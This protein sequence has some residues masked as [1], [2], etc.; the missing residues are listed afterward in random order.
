MKRALGCLLLALSLMGCGHSG[1][2]EDAGKKTS[3]DGK[4][5]KPAE[6]SG[7]TAPTQVSI[8]DAAQAKAGITVEPVRVTEL[9]EYLTASGQ[10]VMNE[11]RTAHIGSY[12][13]GR[14]TELHANIGD[15]VHKGSILA[16][17]H[18]HDVHETIAAYQTALES[19]TRQKT[20][21]AY[22]QRMRDRMVRLLDLKSASR[23]E[24]EKA[25]S[26]L[27]SAQTDLTNSQIS[28]DK[29][30]AHLT[31]ILNLPPSS[32]SSIDENT[33]QIPVISTLSGVVIDRKISVGSVVEPGEEVF[34]VSDLSSVWM[35]AS[36]NET[37]IAKVRVGNSAEIV[38][39]AFPGEE[40]PGRI[41]RLGTELDPRTRTLQVRILVPNRGFKLR[42][43][44][45]VNAK[46]AQ[47][48]SR[49]AMFIP[50]LAIQEIN[51]GSVVFTRRPNN[52]FE[53][54][55][56]QIA[57][58]LNGTAEIAAGL[59]AGDELVVKGSFVVKSEILKSQIGE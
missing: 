14:V 26:D 1:G 47:G 4:G 45:Y 9:P 50:E 27:R 31:D 40:F 42:S 34:T 41:T 19:V 56:V 54:T 8:D 44:M 37:D 17:M 39:Q 25:E 32:L 24:V 53:A 48:L 36:V 29:E 51:G 35:I 13:E 57:T 55:P 11:E 49:Q 15:P 33:E 2:S 23:Q 6:K 3:E 46:L 7:A 10:I 52:V 59:K 43:G 20:M 21:V 22:Q 18:S 5:N 12:T 58:R 30:V 38:S 28:V 16:R